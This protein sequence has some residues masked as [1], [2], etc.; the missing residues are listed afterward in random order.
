MICPVPA[1]HIPEGGLPLNRFLI[2]IDVPEPV[3]RA[4]AVAGLAELPP[5]WCAIPA[6]RASAA[7]G[8]QWLRQGYTAILV[9]PSV[10]VPEEGVT[11]INPSHALAHQFKVRV[12]RQFQYNR[13]FR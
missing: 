1:P 9:V 11:L 6:G 8:S 13:L 10:V 12:V 7:V 2:E 4:R 3:W 5:A